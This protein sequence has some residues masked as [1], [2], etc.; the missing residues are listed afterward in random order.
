MSND[1]WRPNE[2]EPGTGGR[3]SWQGGASN[4]GEGGQP[5]YGA[6]GEQPYGG[7]GQPTYG[8]AAQ[9][10]YGSPI[11]PY[12][13]GPQDDNQQW[14]APAPYGQAPQ[15]QAPYG[16]AVHPRAQSLRTMGI[17]AI[18]LALFCNFFG[19]IMA[20]VVLAQSGGV[21]REIAARQWGGADQVKQARIFAIVALVVGLLGGIG[22]IARYAWSWQ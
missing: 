14:G 18:P 17:V 20:I 1:G 22:S 6:A 11:P 19:M 21:S 12:G 9:P 5:P 13:S 3:A 10:A 15:G 4:H 16:T 2:G 7:T 8:D